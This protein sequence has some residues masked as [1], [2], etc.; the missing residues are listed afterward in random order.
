MSDEAAVIQRFYDCFAQRDAEGMAECYRDDVV[1]T[2]PAFGELHGERARDMWRMLCRNGKDLQVVA[3][4][5]TADD[6]AGSAHWEADYTFSATG[7]PVHNVV[8]AQFEFV[9]GLISRHTDSFSFSA[10]AA[11]AFGPVGS[12]LGRTPILPFVLNRMANRQLDQ[13]QARR[14]GNTD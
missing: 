3:S 10:W 5:V 1:F 6:G 13:F 11:Q 2:D 8:D 12:V 7:R 9:D 4:G 14:S